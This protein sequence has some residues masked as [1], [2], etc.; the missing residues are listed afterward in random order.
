MGA[1]GQHVQ[2][3]VAGQ[4]VPERIAGA[5]D[6]GTAPQH[7]VLDIVADRI[8]DRAADVIGAFVGLL[9][10]LIAG[11]LHHVRIVAGAARQDVDACVVVDRIA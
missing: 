7:Q 10:H 1:A 2:A 8:G 6:G 3:A 11:I 4:A 5:V 9:D